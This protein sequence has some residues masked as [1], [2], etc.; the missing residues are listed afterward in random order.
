[1]I[2]SDVA[3]ITKGPRF[4]CAG[5]ANKIA[6]VLLYDE[7]IEVSRVGHFHQQKPGHA[8]R[9]ENHDAE[10][11]LHLLENGQSSFEQKVSPN[12]EAGN[13]APVPSNMPSRVL[14]SGRSRYSRQ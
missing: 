2:S 8:D 12:D 3:S 9:E 7:V 14:L 5:A 10:W 4:H 6:E 1:M 13:I 11:Q